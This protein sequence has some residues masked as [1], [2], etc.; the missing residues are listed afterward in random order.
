MS[1]GLPLPLAHRRLPED[2]QV[3][4][5]W[6]DG[7]YARSRGLDEA[8]KARARKFSVFLGSN[9]NWD[10]WGNPETGRTMFVDVAAGCLSGSFGD[11]YYWRTSLTW[12]D[13]ST[14]YTAAGRS[15]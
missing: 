3:E 11:R 1:A 15:W 12:D 5:G 4:G 7:V 8:E 10:Y 6:Y 14:A 9:A 2:G 13:G